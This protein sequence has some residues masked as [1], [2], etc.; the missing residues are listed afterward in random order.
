MATTEFQQVVKLRPGFVPARFRLAKLYLRQGA[1]A[2][3]REQCQRILETPGRPA[4]LNAPVL[5]MLS[6][7]LRGLD[8]DPLADELTWWVAATADEVYDPRESR[9]WFDRYL[10]LRG[11]R[12][13]R[14]ETLRRRELDELEQRAVEEVRQAFTGPR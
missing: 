10:A 6:E 2:D 7:A 5:L 3:V 1:Y 13:D 4:R 12:V 14:E 9:P 11:I 8:A